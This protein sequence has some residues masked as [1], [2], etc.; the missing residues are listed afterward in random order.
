MNHNDR[1]SIGKSGELIEKSGELIEKIRNRPG[2]D[3]EMIESIKKFRESIEKS[4][5]S[6]QHAL[7]PYK[8]PRCRSVICVLRGFLYF[9]PK[10]EP[11]L[12]W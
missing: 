10:N 6:M 4:P 3:A 9:S 1:E 11:L 12:F 2:I 5:P 7:K 8:K